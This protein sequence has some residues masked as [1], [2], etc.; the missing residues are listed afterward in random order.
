MKLISFLLIFLTACVQDNMNTNHT[1]DQNKQIVSYNDNT[2]NGGTGVD[3]FDKPVN[4][5]EFLPMYKTYADL[6]KVFSFYEIRIKTT[7]PIH[8]RFVNNFE[9]N[10][11]NA[12]EVLSI[13]DDASSEFWIIKSV[14]FQSSFS[15]TEIAIISESAFAPGS[16]EMI[17]IYAG[18]ASPEIL[19]YK[20]SNLND[21]RARLYNSS[22]KIEL[23]MVMEDCSELWQN[24]YDG[25]CIQNYILCSDFEAYADGNKF[26]KIK[27]DDDQEVYCYPEN[28]V[29]SCKN[30][31]TQICSQM[32]DFIQY[33]NQ[34]FYGLFDEQIVK[35]IQ[36]NSQVAPKETIDL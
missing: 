12:P 9:F 19:Y 10:K 6:D 2:G 33:N 28:N 20:A 7:S 34:M 5:E 16:I 17:E 8:K 11:L 3:A 13:S 31:T 35:N 36:C 15:L 21:Q 18:I 23:N 32:P 24:N 26:C 29:D 25:Q 30:S 4:P 22:N 1:S 27:R 14:Y